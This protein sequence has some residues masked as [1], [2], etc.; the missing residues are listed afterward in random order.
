MLPFVVI[1]LMLGLVLVFFGSKFERRAREAASWP[2][3]VG[4]LE[5]CEVVEVPGI[6]TDDFSTWQLQ[7]SYSYIV[8]GKTHHS[9]QYAFGYGDGRDDTQHRINADALKRSPQLYVHYDPAHP[10]EAVLSTELQTNL[11]KLGYGC[12]V[13]AAIAALLAFAVR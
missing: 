3:V 1:L 2:V 8:N 13:T 7:V 5:R 6:G 12:L 9:T 11:S 4:Q 10:S